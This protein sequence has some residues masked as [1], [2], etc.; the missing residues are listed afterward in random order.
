[1]DNSSSNIQN[2]TLIAVGENGEQ[3]YEFQVKNQYEF[4]SKGRKLKVEVIEEA[5]GI[6]L[7]CCEGVR[8][9]FEVVSVK[10]NTYEVMVNGV[11]Y[12][13]AVETPFS[14]K[15]RE[16]LAAQ[17]PVNLNEELHAP[18]PGKIVAVHVKVGQ[19]VNA[20]DSLLVLEAMKMQNTLTADSKGTVIG[21][22][23]KEGQNVSKD[24]LLVEIKK[25]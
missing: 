9:P 23:V 13:F 6:N 20:G 12:H 24:D 8:Y 4:S 11:S 19:E 3:N 5:D 1:M 22:H 25:A 14:L 16:I 2:R 10:Q 18:M 7:F 17:R 21:V 15:R